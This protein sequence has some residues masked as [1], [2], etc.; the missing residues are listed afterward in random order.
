MTKHEKL[1]EK[2]LNGSASFTFDELVRLLNGYGYEMSVRGRT[3]GS[4]VLFFHP[5]T[6]D[7]ILIHRPHPQKEI[8]QYVIKLIVEKLKSN[9]MI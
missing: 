1:V 4:A 9:N 3:T 5:A 2:L 7:K 8:K 6:E